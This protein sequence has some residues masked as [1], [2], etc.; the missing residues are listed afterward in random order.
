MQNQSRFLRTCLPLVLAAF[1]AL[2]GSLG[3]MHLAG[4]SSSLMVQQMVVFLVSIVVLGP[5]FARL[6]PRERPLAWV[7]LALA[8]LLLLPMVMSGEVSGPQR[9]L[10]LGRFRLYLAP[11]VI[12]A[13][14]LTLAKR[15]SSPASNPVARE[16]GA[17][18]LL[19]G[20]ALVLQPDAA[21]ATAFAVSVGWLLFN[22]PASVRTRGVIW[23]VV[24]ACAG[25]SWQRPDPLLPVPH[26]EGVFE[27]ANGLGGWAL[28][29]AILVAVLP[30]ATLLWQARR[31]DVP[32]AAAVGLYYGTL[33]CLAPLQI[34]PVPLLGFG[35]GPL[36]GY[37]LMVMLASR[38]RV[39]LEA[40]R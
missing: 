19:A 35:A 32:G 29:G 16:A 27:L 8:A 3:L 6:R 5:L 1:P 37:V 38:L 33:L 2:L 9:W 22:V 36:I 28:M 7:P 13:L 21:Q 12:P 15:T 20:V 23:L 18:I 26:V 14:L 40:G 10:L 25:L 11:I 39:E 4:V 31:S 17:A 30:A 34:T 24:A